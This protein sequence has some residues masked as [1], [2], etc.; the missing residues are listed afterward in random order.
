MKTKIPQTV[1]EII[2]YAN[3]LTEPMDRLHFLICLTTGTLDELPPP[4]GRLRRIR[5]RRQNTVQS[6]ETRDPG[7]AAS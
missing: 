1:Q 2:D 6:Q 5:R 4:V 3:S 7:T